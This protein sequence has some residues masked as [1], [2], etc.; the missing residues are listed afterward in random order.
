MSNQGTTMPTISPTDVTTLPPFARRM[1]EAAADVWEEGYKQP[2]L[3]ELG[4][5]TLAPERFA[6]YLIQ[7]NLYLNDYAKVHALAV[8]K[9]DDVEIMR[10]M[11]QV[12]MNIFNMEQGHHNEALRA[13]GMDPDE[14]AAIGQSAFAHAY[15]SNIM[16]IAYT[17]DLVDIL[18]AV[19]PCAWVYADYGERLMRDFGDNLQDNP[20]GD[21]IAMYADPAFWSGGV[22]LIEHIERLV[23]GLPEERLAELEASFV[24]GVQNEYLFWSTAYDRQLGWKPGWR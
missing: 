11:A 24:R 22:W 7:D 6:F 19:L 14:A 18:V 9:T 8:T 16:E 15:T 21:W 12:Q 1:R 20:Y 4:E 3:Q 23:Q 5:G 17:K 10:F 13:Y 2:F